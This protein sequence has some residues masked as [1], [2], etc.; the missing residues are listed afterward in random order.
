M[1]QRHGF[2]QLEFLFVHVPLSVTEAILILNRNLCDFAGKGTYISSETIKMSTCFISLLMLAAMSVANSEK[3]GPVP[4]PLAL[5]NDTVLIN[6]DCRR[7]DLLPHRAIILE[8][9]KNVTHLAVRLLHCHT[10]PVGL[11]TNIT[12][13]LTSVTL[14]SEDAVQL[15]EGTFSGLEYISK[16]RLFG[17]ASLIT[18]SRTVFEPL[19]NIE[20]LILDRLGQNHIKLSDLGKT[21]QQLSGSSITDIVLTNIRSAV[22]QRGDR[23]LNM[24]DFAIKN[25][26][27]KSLIVTGVQ[28]NYVQSIRRALPALVSFC[29]V[30]DNRQFAGTRPVVMDF[31]FLSDTLVNFTIH[32]SKERE[33]HPAILQNVSND[34]VLIAQ[35][36]EFKQDFTDLYTYM[37]NSSKSEECFC[38]MIFKL[39]A[40]LSRMTINEQP[41]IHN[42]M[43][44]PTCFDERNVLEY[45]DLSRTP[46]PKDFQGITG[47]LALKYLSLESTGIELLPYNFIQDTFL[48]CKC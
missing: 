33:S 38:G 32:L 30:R 6:L 18:L 28:L 44:K 2:L 41:L 34:D 9:H 24:N 29:S 26:S 10:V 42:V 15:L 45:G 11:F 8:L 14:A 17:F 39:G 4:G 48:L 5:T 20:T 23:I 36:P 12:D 3:C 46:L 21:I 43:H 47:L 35:L 7:S 40:S 25:A 37:T 22:K 27:V 19:R 16:L 13:N 31:V 1:T